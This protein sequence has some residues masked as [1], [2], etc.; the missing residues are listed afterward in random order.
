L[1]TLRE[2]ALLA[3]NGDEHLLILIFG[4]G[5]EETQDIFVGGG[6]NPDNAPRLKM[7]AVKR[8]LPSNASVAILMTPCYSGGWLV[9]PDITNSRRPFLNTT[10]ITGS[11]PEG[12]TRS[13]PMSQS[14]GRANGS[15]IATAIVKS[16]IEIEEDAARE[17]NEVIG[18]PT[19]IQLAHSILNTFNKMAGIP[20]EQTIH[21]A[22][23][24]DEWETEYGRRLGLPLAVYK[25]RWESLREIPASGVLQSSG[26]VRFQEGEA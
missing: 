12:E 8:L 20:E 11:G 2:Q 1:S 19:Y 18:H 13:W 7:A 14:V 24:D 22:A 17:T 15:I 3:A 9:N 25:D 6:A 16:L 4:H 5:D 21:F 23:Q 26:K 10:A